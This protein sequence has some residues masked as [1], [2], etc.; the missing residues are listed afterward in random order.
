MN[1][2][3]KVRWYQFKLSSLF[4]AIAVSGI[5][6]GTF[7]VPIAR[8]RSAV[9]EV[10][11]LGGTVVYED[12]PEDAHWFAKEAREWLPRD[13]FDSVVEVSFSGNSE[14]VDSD[15]EVIRSFE[16]LEVLWLSYT[17]MSDSGITKLKPLKRLKYIRVRGTRV[18]EAGIAELQAR[19]P[20]CQIDR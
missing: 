10:T 17:K 5:L 4:F 11:R 1:V 9:Q 14:I 12:I 7:L 13:C 16:R 20:S 6:V 3:R 8:Q 2:R 18:S 19:L 15:L